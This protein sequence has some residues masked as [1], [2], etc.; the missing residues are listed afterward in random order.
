MNVE[1]EKIIA[2]LGLEPLPVEGG[3]FRQVWVSAARLPDG[4]GAASTIWFLLTREDFS[5][6]HRVD[7]EEV[8]Q[9]H[10]GD[11]V[12]H[13]QL[14]AEAGGLREARLGGPRAA[15]LVV[16]AGAWQAARL[17]PG[18][19]Q[20]G[21]ALLTCTMAPAWDEKGFELGRRGEL[22]RQFPAAADLIAALTR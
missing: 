7:A 22:V 19:G 3:F 12:A 6:W 1:A 4:R 17:A 20:H 21:W 9:F 8:W 14:T 16:P 5:A 15:P 13:L 10:S 11:P 18:P 2:Q